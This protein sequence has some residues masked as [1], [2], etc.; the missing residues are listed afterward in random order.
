MVAIDAREGGPDRLGHADEAVAVEEL[1]AKLL[2]GWI[3]QVFAD[4]SQM[5]S[6]LRR[7]YLVEVAGAA[8]PE[9]D[10]FRSRN[11]RDAVELTGLAVLVLDD[12]PIILD[13]PGQDPIEACLHLAPDALKTAGAR[14]EVERPRD[15]DRTFDPDDLTESL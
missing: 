3:D 15:Q 8:L 1:P 5:R 7:G 4:R 10:P 12:H 6:D 9:E 2:L 13:Q 11:P 14:I